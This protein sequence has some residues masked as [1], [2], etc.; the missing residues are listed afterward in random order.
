MG[1]VVLRGQSPPAARVVRPVHHPRRR[2]IQPRWN[3]PL[4]RVPCGTNIRRP[5]D[6]PLALLTQVRVAGENQRTLVRFALAEELGARTH[7]EVSAVGRQ[8]GLGLIGPERV[9]ALADDVLVE[10]LPV[11]FGRFGVGGVDIRSGSIIRKPVNRRTVGVGDQPALLQQIVVVAVGGHKARPDADHRL[12]AH[13]VQL[14]VHPRRIGPKLGVKVELPHLRVIEPVHHQH[15]GRQMA[16]AILLR[17]IQQFLL[18]RVPL[19]ALDVSESRLGR[20]VRRPGQ[21]LVAREDLIRR[22]AGN[23]KERNPVAHLRGPPRLL[24][25]ARF[26]GCFGGVV[27]QQPVAFVSQQKGHTE[28]LPR[29]RVIIRPAM[30]HMAAM[31][32]EAL[33]VLPQA[34]IMLIL[35]RGK[36]RAHGVKL[37]VCWTAV[38]QHRSGSVL[39]IGDSLCPAGHLQQLLAVGRGKGDVRR[40]GRGREEARAVVPGRALRTLDAGHDAIRFVNVGQLGLAGAPA[41]GGGRGNQSIAGRGHGRLTLEAQRHAQDIRRIRLKNNGAAAPRK[42]DL[43]LLSGKGSGKQQENGR[44]NK[45]ATQA[46]G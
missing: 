14:L 1:R 24:V 26:D 23:H 8:V 32:E 40:R 36:A 7:L 28:A 16:V 20:Q 11:P 33:L 10:G 37:G 41:C 30:H 19:L 9:E 34:V 21:L 13:L 25:E 45:T 46:N 17:H 31:V 22:R 5:Q 2:H 27:P 35:R 42:N 44:G 39:L 43:T 15:V 29:R 18:T 38:G 12:K 6:R 3:L 4:V